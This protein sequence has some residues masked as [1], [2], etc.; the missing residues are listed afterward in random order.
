MT[1]LA[2]QKFREEA[3]W[4]QT[5]GR[6]SMHAPVKPKL[7]KV[8]DTATKARELSLILPTAPHFHSHIIHR[9]ALVDY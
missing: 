3:Q 9:T 2:V 6:T 8:R 4:V 1:L 7:I 5:Q